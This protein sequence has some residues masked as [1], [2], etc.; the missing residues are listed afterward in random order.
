LYRNAYHLVLYKHGDLLY[1]GMF[2]NLFIIYVFIYYFILICNNFF[3]C[4]GLQETIKNK[5]ITVAKELLKS[6][7][8]NILE[9][10]SKA[11]DEHKGIIIFI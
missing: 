8:D 11:Y 10:I 1:N 7:D 5:A 9:S 4:I 2:I 6:Q 3:T